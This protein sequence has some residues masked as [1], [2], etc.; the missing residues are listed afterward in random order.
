MNRFF[1]T[2]GRTILAST[3]LVIAAAGLGL[4]ANAAYTAMSGGACCFP[5]SPCCFPGSPCCANGA[6]AGVADAR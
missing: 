5:G 3:F 1:S 2:R 6:H 4:G